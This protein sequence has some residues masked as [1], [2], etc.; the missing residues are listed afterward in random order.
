MAAPQVA[1]C[2]CLFSL[3]KTAAIPVDTHV[4]QLAARYYLPN[5]RGARW[6]IRQAAGGACL[7]VSPASSSDALGCRAGKNPSKAHNQSVEA[8][9]QERFG[10]HAGWAHN[11]LFIAELPSM[12]H[13]LP[14]PDGELVPRSAPGASASAGTVQRA[15]DPAQGAAADGVPK[16]KR[17]RSRAVK[18]RLASVAVK[19]EAEDTLAVK[20]GLASVAVKVQAEDALGAPV[21]PGCLVEQVVTLRTWKRRKLR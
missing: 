11:T 3:D 6:L 5:L 13:L 1:A 16:G 2:I 19:V 20:A 14:G 7:N 17:G 4:W 21:A 15:A 10:S 18:A 9:L 8:A 12:R